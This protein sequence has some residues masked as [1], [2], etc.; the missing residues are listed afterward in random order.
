MRAQPLAHEINVD[1]IDLDG[2]DKFLVSDRSPPD[3]MTLSEL[4]GLLTGIAIGPT[5][6]PPSEWVPLIWGGYAPEFADLD[7]ANAILRCIMARYNEIIQEIADDALA[8]IFWVDL[9]GTFIAASWAEGFLQAIMLRADAW[10]PLFKSK[11]DGNL[12]LPILSLCGDEDGQSLL[13]LAPA[14]EEDIADEVTELIPGC[15]MAIAAYWRRKG[16][17]QVTMSLKAEPRRISS[18]VKA[19]IGRNDPCPCGSGR[20]FKRCCGKAERSS[21]PTHR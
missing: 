19:K 12:L 13:G 3:S 8:P 6:V 15:V 4:D 2:L 21:T 10:K 16:S 9:D 20:K 7:E 5:L 14:E 18:D 1:R 17:K 11:R